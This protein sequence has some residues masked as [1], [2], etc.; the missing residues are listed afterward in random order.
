M[1]D[2]VDNI[3]SKYKIYS[4]RATVYYPDTGFT[5]DY[6]FQAKSMKEAREYFMNEIY[7]TD[8]VPQQSGDVTITINRK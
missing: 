4:F 1:I 3:H 5:W 6:V 7:P 8:L 2:M